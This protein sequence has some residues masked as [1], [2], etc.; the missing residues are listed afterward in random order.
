MKAYCIGICVVSD[1]EEMAAKPLYYG[2]RGRSNILFTAGFAGNAVNEVGT[3]AIDVVCA[4]VFSAGSGAN[5]C[6]FPL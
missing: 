5:E 4:R 2:V 3:I 6:A 1:V